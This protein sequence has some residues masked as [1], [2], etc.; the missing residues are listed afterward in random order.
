MKRHLK[1]I[2]I[3]AV[4]ISGLFV[5]F[6]SFTDQRAMACDCPRPGS[7]REELQR[8]D[9]VFSGEVRSVSRE[10]IEFAHEPKTLIKRLMNKRNSA[11]A[12]NLDLI[13]EIVE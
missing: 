8:V 4:I 3:K 5:S 12:K 6:A 7:P 2:H 1:R 11:K 10:K 9:A 13:Q